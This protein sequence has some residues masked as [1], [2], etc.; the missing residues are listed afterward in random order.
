MP[1]GYAHHP[2][3]KP[4]CSNHPNKVVLEGCAF[5]LTSSSH[6][7][8]AFI[9][10]TTLDPFEGY[11]GTL[12]FSPSQFSEEYRRVTYHPQATP[13][14]AG[15]PF[16]DDENQKEAPS[17]PCAFL[18]CLGRCSRYNQRPRKLKRAHEWGVCIYIYMYSPRL[19][20]M[21]VVVWKQ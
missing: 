8:F 6:H 5:F 16:T 21:M 1:P 9:L 3:A 15:R 13:L 19:V 12:A 10:P 18:C 20:S 11:F 4:S 14:S 17:F 7:S 2:P